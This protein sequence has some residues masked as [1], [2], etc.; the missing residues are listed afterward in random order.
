VFAF[1]LSTEIGW[2]TTLKD[3]PHIKQAL[4]STVEA[5]FARMVFP[6]Q[7]HVV[8][9]QPGMLRVPAGPNKESATCT[10]R[11]ST[12]GRADTRKRPGARPS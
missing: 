6:Q 1:E 3:A 10:E 11:D 2:Q 8:L 7:H 12:D 4:A 9:F 5:V